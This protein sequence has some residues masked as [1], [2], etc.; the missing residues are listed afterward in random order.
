MARARVALSDALVKASLQ[1]NIR[2][3][4]I[5]KTEEALLESRPEGLLN[6]VFLLVTP[7]GVNGKA[8][9]A[10]NSYSHRNPQPESL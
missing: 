10:W 1:E 6:R 4:R 3:I 5:P 7:R 8:P 2:E 9:T